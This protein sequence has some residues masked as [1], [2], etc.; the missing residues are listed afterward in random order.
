MIQRANPNLIGELNREVREL[1]E[2]AETLV[3]ALEVAQNQLLESKEVFSRLEDVT[4]DVDW[5][6][7][8]D[9]QDEC[10]KALTTI[11]AALTAAEVKP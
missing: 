4:S 3:K 6:T 8:R 1:R 2:Q 9:Q 10:A 11:K 7:C 5:D